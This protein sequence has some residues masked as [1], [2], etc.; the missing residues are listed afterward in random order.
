MKVISV[1]ITRIVDDSAVPPFVECLLVDAHGEKHC[2]VEKDAIFSSTP[3]KLDE[4]PRQGVLAC[5][6][7]LEWVDSAGR[8]LVRASTTKPWGVESTAGGS[9]FVILAEHLQEV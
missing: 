1:K 2:F 6:V 3:G 9:T 7:E 8:S 4:L 5:E